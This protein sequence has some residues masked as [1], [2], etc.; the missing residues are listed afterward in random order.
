M[1][2]TNNTYFKKK[3]LSHDLSLKNTQFCLR[4]GMNQSLEIGSFVL[5]K[6]AK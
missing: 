3:F 4:N 1:S 6:E 2:G 5:N